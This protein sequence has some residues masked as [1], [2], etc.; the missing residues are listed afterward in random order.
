MMAKMVAPP[1]TS[2]NAATMDR[3]SH[4]LLRR[5]LGPAIG[6]GGQAAGGGGKAGGDIGET[7]GGTLGNGD[8]EGGGGGGWPAES[9][10][11]F[12]RDDVRLYHRLPAARLPQGQVG[13]CG[14]MKRSR[15]VSFL[16]R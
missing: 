16:P 10:V 8:G 4:V 6:A 12:N 11:I 9:E 5:P 2:R 7:G 3:I 13:K 15:S 1:T 14:M